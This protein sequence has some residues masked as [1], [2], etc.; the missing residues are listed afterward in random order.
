MICG[1]Y[2]VLFCSLKNLLRTAMIKHRGHSRELR[3]LAA[4][5]D[6]V[7]ENQNSQYYMGPEIM[8]EID[9]DITARNVPSMRYVFFK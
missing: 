9:D 6:L 4:Q 5:I 1:Q 2:D 8:D 7:E 3:R